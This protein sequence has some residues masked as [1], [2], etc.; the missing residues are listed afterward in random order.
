[1]TDD[2]AR[3]SRCPG[4]GSAP[5][6]G[7]GPRPA[8]RRPFPLQTQAPACWR[9]QALPLTGIVL[10]G[11][12][13]AGLAL[14]VPGADSVGSDRRTAA[15]VAILGIAGLVYLFAVG[16]VL[17]RSGGGSVVPVLL[18]ALAMRIPPLLAPPFLSSDMYRYVWDGRVQMAGINPY[19][20]M[21][22]DPVLRPL[23]DRA[24]F[25]HINRA[26]TARTIYPPAAQMVFG[27]VAAVSD[28]ILAM[29]LAMIGFEALACW[30]MLRLLALVRLPRERL[31]IYAW[32][33]LAVWAFAGNGHV[34]AIAIGLLSL[35][36]L[37]RATRRDIWTGIVLGAAILVKFLPAA[38]APSLWRRDS[39]WRTP[40]A[41]VLVIVGLYVCYIGAGAH[42]L[43]F[44]P[45]Y[46][47][48]E[49]LS[50][51]TGIWLLAGI[52]L[53]APPTP[54]MA[55]IYAAAVLLGLMALAA[56]VAFRARP[57]EPAADVM[58]VCGDAALLAA[59]I[60][61]VISPHYPWY[62]VWVA[63]PCCVAARWSIIWLGVAPVLLYLDPWHERFFWPCLVYL[64]A[65][66]LAVHDLWRAVSLRGAGRGGDPGRGIA[67]SSRCSQ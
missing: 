14:H 31:L 30:A 62:F 42:V 47:G 46:F 56:W 8:A 26:A 57:R 39:P 48:D 1:M 40:V 13:V 51:G 22:A 7:P 12:I 60:T 36:L 44:L 3:L 54:R 38:V 25:P 10:V 9:R 4:K 55:R 43:G 28:S 63:L 20:Y 53:V 58:R 17:R 64:P 19:R 24:I 37:L 61:V 67:A 50:Q 15:F 11:L 27:A 34:D 18:I 45:G 66:G 52:G 33:P 21:P 29:K 16:L 32:N 59:A 23:R 2:A 49:D 35:A 65:A 6:E 41:A 5:G